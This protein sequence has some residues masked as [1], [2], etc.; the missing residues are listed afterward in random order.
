LTAPI[1]HNLDVNRFYFEVERKLG[2]EGR[3][4]PI[5]ADVLANAVLL[6]KQSG[7]PLSAVNIR[8]RLDQ[9]EDILK[10]FRNTPQTNMSLAS[11]THAVIRAHLATDNTIS[12]MRM[13]H[14]RQEFGIFADD[15]ENVMM[16]N[17]FFV[18]GNYR[19]A[20]KVAIQCMLQEEYAVPVVSQAALL[21]AYKYACQLPDLPDDHAWNPLM[22]NETEPEVKDDDEETMVRVWFKDNDYHDEHFDLTE[23][24]HLLG[25][26]IAKFAEHGLANLSQNKDADDVIKPAL[27]L[28]GYAL[29]QKWDTAAE[30]CAELKGKRVPQSCLDLIQNYAA[31]L[32]D[33]PENNSAAAA[34][35]EKCFEV[36]SQLDG[37]E[38]AL[39]VEGF[40]GKELKISVEAHESGLIEK[41]AQVYQDWI[42]ERE[43]ELAKQMEM[44]RKELRRQKLEQTKKELTEKEEKLFF[45]ENFD[46]MEREKVHK[47]NQWASTFPPKSGI[48]MPVKE[49]VKDDYVPPEMKRFGKAKP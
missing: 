34:E 30:I 43:E 16:L 41:Q 6:P 11:M 36:L 19:D 40:L 32:P 31:N 49:T 27:E 35:K 39:D 29:F 47:Y 21:S 18:A 1:F 28:L 42:K 7:K 17:H 15:F 4:S 12:L 10:R 23:R 24:H 37:D 26:T 45:F 14:N 13:L 9:L 3:G 46:Q 38:G 2:R 20:A 44:Y 22:P 25:K 5:D 48:K 33:S 8:D